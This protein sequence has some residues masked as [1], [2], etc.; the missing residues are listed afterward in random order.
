MKN[1]DEVDISLIAK[2][3][4]LAFSMVAPYSFANIG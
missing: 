1:L 3:L 4:D 2:V